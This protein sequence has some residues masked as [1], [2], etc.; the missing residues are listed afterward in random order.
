[1]TDF[2]SVDV[3]AV[4]PAAPLAHLCRVVDGRRVAGHERERVV[5]ACITNIASSPKSAWGW[6]LWFFAILAILQ[7]V[8]L[9]RADGD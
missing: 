1:M 3:H 6:H 7:A 2:V 5:S 8:H 4:V 9:W